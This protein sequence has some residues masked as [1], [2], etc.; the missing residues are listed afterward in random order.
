MMNTANTLENQIA[1]QLEQQLIFLQSAAS[2]ALEATSLSAFMEA[3]NRVLR[4]H[5]GKLPDAI[6]AAWDRVLI[7]DADDSKTVRDWLKNIVG[8][9]DDQNETEP[10]DGTNPTPQINAG[11]NDDQEESD[12]Q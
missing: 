12:T 7:R 5:G 10:G 8:I 6:Q 1:D 3:M 11:T 2:Q 9:A 4:C